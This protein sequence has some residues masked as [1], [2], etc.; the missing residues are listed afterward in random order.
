MTH[1]TEDQKYRL[2]REGGLTEEAD[3]QDGEYCSDC[4]RTHSGWCG[5]EQE[6]ADLAA[7]AAE[8]E[9]LKRRAS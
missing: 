7:E 6:A 3:E 1:L 9:R 2:Y 8:E 4:L 5:A